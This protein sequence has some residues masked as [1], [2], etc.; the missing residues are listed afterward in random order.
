M[1]NCDEVKAKF[2]QN[3]GS[4]MAKNARSRDV[5]FKSWTDFNLQKTQDASTAVKLFHLAHV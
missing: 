2:T 5:F 3:A 4:G 1:M